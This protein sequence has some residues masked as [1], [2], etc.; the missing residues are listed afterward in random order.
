[1]LP[2][3]LSSTSLR[4]RQLHSGGTKGAYCIGLYRLSV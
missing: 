4:G 3:C 2:M 1:M